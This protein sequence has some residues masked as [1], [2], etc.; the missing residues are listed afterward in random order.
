MAKKVQAMLKLQV[1]AAKAAPSQQVGYGARSAGRKHHGLLQAVQRPSTAK[2]PEGM[3]TPVV[4][5][6]YSDRTFTFIT[7]DSAGFRVAEARRKIVKGSA[8]TR[9]VTKSAKLPKKQV[10]DIAKTK[11]PDLNTTNMETAIRTVTGHSAKYGPGIRMD[12]EQ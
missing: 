8:G 6:V 5:T 4:I 7:Q 10:Q 11:L 12:L 3:V 1:P 2:D 9:I